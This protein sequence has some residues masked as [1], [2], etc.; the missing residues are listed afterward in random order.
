[1]RGFEIITRERLDQ[2]RQ[3]DLLLFPPGERDQPS[4]IIRPEE[5]IVLVRK[6]A[7]RTGNLQVGVNSYGHMFL[8]FFGRP[9][10]EPAVEKLIVLDAPASDEIRTFFK[11]YWF[12]G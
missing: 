4:R 2:D 7:F 8:R 10:G 9:P 12:K 11:S 5:E 6:E 1:M 3:D